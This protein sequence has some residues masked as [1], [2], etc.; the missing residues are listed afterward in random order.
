MKDFLISIITVSFNSEETISQTIESVLNQTD[1]NIEYIIV[2]GGST[3]KTFKIINSYKN[4]F[5]LKGINYKFISEPDTGIYNA[6]NKGLKMATGNWVSFLGSDDFYVL[7]AIETYNKAFSKNVD[8][9]Y[10]NVD[11]I[12]QKKTIKKI[13]GIWSWKIFKRY[14]NIAHVGAFH[15][16]DFFKKYGFFDESYKIAGDYELL[17]RAKGNLRT[18][19]IEKTTAKMLDGGASN[20]NVIK[21]LKETKRAKINTGNASIILCY[22]DF[23]VALVKFY[24]KKNVYAVIR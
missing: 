15:N 19:K 1:T 16:I 7:N 20:S 12:N 10:S 23:I 5:S 21:V 22:F 8:L 6:F 13:N 24:L 14:M 4:D 11:V 18:F 9:I 3:D 17:L 2:D